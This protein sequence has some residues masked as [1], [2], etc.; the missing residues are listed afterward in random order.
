VGP[1]VLRG[2]CCPYR[3]DSGYLQR[4]WRVAFYRV[5]HCLGGDTTH[6]EAPYWLVDP[7]AGTTC[8]AEMEPTL[9]MRLA[10]VASAAGASLSPGQ[11]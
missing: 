5:A 3:H 10:A 11:P 4:A 8:A 7:L 9:I 6:R 2:R 1:G